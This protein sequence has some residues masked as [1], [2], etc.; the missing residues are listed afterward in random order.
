MYAL[1]GLKNKWLHPYLSSAYL[2]SLA[3]TVLILYVMNLPVSNAVQGAYFVA[4][5]TTGL[6]IGGAALVFK[7]MTEGLG[8]LL[9]G[10]CLSM[11]FLVLSPGGLLTSTRSIS[12]FI[13]AFS[14]AAYATSFSHYTRPYGLIGSCS[15][16]G[17]TVVILGIDCFSR[18]GLKEFWAYI[19]NLNSNLF[20]LGATTYP[21]TRGIR[22]EIAAIIAI[23]LAGIVSQVRL[24]KF[25]E[26]RRE[27]RA[28][29]KLNAQRN[30][31][32]EAN[33]S[34]GV[35][36]ANAP[37]KR[38]W[39]VYG[40]KDVGVT[41]M[42]SGASTRS[43][44]QDHSSTVTFLPRPSDEQIEMNKIS[45]S[46][47]PMMGGGLVKG[48]KDH[49][50]GVVVGVISEDIPVIR[51][52]GDGH[53]IPIDQINDNFNTSGNAVRKSPTTDGG[54]II[55]AVGESQTLR[56]ISSRSSKRVSGAPEVVPLPFIVPE[57]EDDDRSSLATFA[58]DD[59][60]RSSRRCSEASVP[61]RSSKGSR[62]S[63]QAMPK[64]ISVST[65]DLVAQHEDNDHSSV[66]ATVDDI[67]DYEDF[68]DLQEISPQQ[69]LA[70]EGHNQTDG[71]EHLE[72]QPSPIG[73]ESP[74]IERN[75]NATSS[76]RESN[77]NATSSVGDSNTQT[78]EVSSESIPQ[79]PPEDLEHN[80]GPGRQ[81]VSKAINKESPTLSTDPE[82]HRSSVTIPKLDQDAEVEEERSIVSIG[83]TKE[84]LPPAM[85][86]F[87]KSYRTNEWAKHISNAEAPEFE[88]LKQ[89]DYLVESKTEI[90]EAPAPVCVQELQQ[91]AE[92]SLTTP[93]PARNSRPA[94]K[95]SGSQQV[96]QNTSYISLHSAPEI[97][98]PDFVN[99]SRTDLKRPL[100]SMYSQNS[101]RQ[102]RNSSAPIIGEEFVNSSIRDKFQPQIKSQTQFATIA[103]R[104]TPLSFAQR[105]STTLNKRSRSSLS[106]VSPAPTH[107]AIA[108]S[109]NASTSNLLASDSQL[110]DDKQSLS[111]RRKV[112]RQSSLP[113][114]PLVKST[115][116]MTFQS[117]VQTPLPPATALPHRKSLTLAPEAREAQLTSW[118]A[119]VQ[120]ELYNQSVPRQTIERQRS[121][122]L[123]ERSQAE[124]E[125]SMEMQ[126]RGIIDSMFD[127]RMRSGEM[128]EAHREA[129][130]RM[131]QQAS[132]H[133]S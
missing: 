84:S 113:V 76:V 59:G 133:V 34:Q 98:Y 7:E 9:G 92:S 23:F 114:S 95:R 80:E 116:L 78:A 66:A 30:F 50:G 21:L 68:G 103:A 35:K 123:Q 127:R 93:S 47:P 129:M 91:T 25:I 6:I 120:A 107:D 62:R 48:S 60:Q 36:Y 109:S 70:E 108:S 40:G 101:S 67:T 46:P 27:K 106:N 24:W 17:A 71:D 121:A 1:V 112:L 87:V 125:R 81:D 74:N 104:P 124:R 41:S 16:S 88:E 29:E 77:Y 130:R 118:R 10:F 14:L 4:I 22:V 85:P 75:H 33:I 132:K 54:V 31:R 12:A 111:A 18:A 11:W 45:S 63:S 100:N 102:L 122:L 19:W 86:K 55:D 117:T 90:N 65:E 79:N 56:Q 26:A 42:D 119:S 44:K 126:K 97:Q 82:Y 96:G 2:A 94:S 57:D 110:D 58:D 73:S 51:P 3:V 131:Q 61:R 15:F 69:S 43:P 5:I 72:S 64:T 49:D 13:V 39:T 28:S 128:I 99:G 8:C 37:E 115:P 20:P 53:P 83:L 89:V 38:R 105:T 52:G 32:Q